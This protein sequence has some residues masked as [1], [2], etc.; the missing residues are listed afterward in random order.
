MYLVF[1]GQNRQGYG[2]GTREPLYSLK[3]I[4]ALTQLAHKGRCC[5][6]CEPVQPNEEEGPQ[7]L[8]V[9]SA[10]EFLVNLNEDS[11]RDFHQ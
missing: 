3:T 7:W 11:R 6:Y 4:Q 8:A 2:H 10:A 1:M 9:C 5:I